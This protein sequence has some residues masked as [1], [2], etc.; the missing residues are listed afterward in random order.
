MPF[1]K[2]RKKKNDDED[3]NKILFGGSEKTDSDGEDSHDIIERINNHIYFYSDVNNKSAIEFK[4]TVTKLK[5]ELTTLYNKF[6]IQPIIHLHI[7][8]Y[9]GCLYSAFCIIDTIREIQKEGFDVYT[10]CEGKVASAGTLI[11]VSGT[12][13]F[14]SEN[15]VMLIHQLSS[16]FWGKFT[17]IEDDWENCNMLM[18]KMKKIYKDNTKFKKKELDNLLKHDLWLEAKEC[19]EKGIVDEII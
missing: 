6:E 11:S 12:K 8:S 2:G 19:L 18:N 7:N 14:I 1:G 9:G 5:L 16:V 3:F 17:E 15:A 4:K 10:Y 13:R